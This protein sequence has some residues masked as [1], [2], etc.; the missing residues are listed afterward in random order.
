MV[1]FYAFQDTKYN[2]RGGRGGEWEE[3][4][5]DYRQLAK[6]VQKESAKVKKAKQDEQEGNEEKEEKGKRE[7]KEEEENDEEYLCNRRCLV[8]L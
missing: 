4:A 5:L 7:E 8:C 3:C 2:Q 1:I 6:P